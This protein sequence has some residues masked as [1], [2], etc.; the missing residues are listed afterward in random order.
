[1]PDFKRTLT[2]VG[3]ACVADQKHPHAAMAARFQSLALMFSGKIEFMSKGLMNLAEQ[4]AALSYKDKDP[5]DVKV[6]YD[7]QVDSHLLNICTDVEGTGRVKQVKLS[8]LGDRISGM[9]SECLYP[10]LDQQRELIAMSMEAEVTPDEMLEV[11]GHF[12]FVQIND[13]GKDVMSH[14]PF[15]VRE[16]A[17][18]AWNP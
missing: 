11:A 4:H 6:S 16:A 8:C 1:V 2:K 7:S 10:E 13:D 14:M 9:V 18:K 15:C 12:P 17:R 5:D 3:A